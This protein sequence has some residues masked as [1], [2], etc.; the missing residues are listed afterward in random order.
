MAKSRIIKDLANGIVD[1][2]T[3]LKRT[4]ILLQDLKNND[5]L[6]WVN[7]E[8]GGYSNDTDVPEYRIISGQLYGTYFKGSLANH[9]IY[10]DVPLPLGKMG[11]EE[12]QAILSTKIRTAIGAL[13]ETLDENMTGNG[14]SKSISADYYPT[15]AL[16]NNDL[17]M[18][19]TS[20]EV[21]LNMPQVR[22]IFSVVESK[23]LDILYF[24][25]KQFGILDELD[26]DTESKTP[27]ELEEIN[28]QI[29]FLVYNDNSVHIGDS[30]Q[31][32]SSTVASKI[33]KMG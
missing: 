4:K 18:I 15:I 6:D 2:Q 33:D 24:L 26:I 30:N 32:K 21:K 12:K 17:Y 27:E 19:I 5:I 16:S 10:P 28:R 29:Y 14:L 1:T 23:L 20:A 7:N 31:F 11:E 25:E 13:K 9:M 8:I 3:A 22:N